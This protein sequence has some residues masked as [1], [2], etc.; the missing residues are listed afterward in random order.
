M[1]DKV[2]GSTQYLYTFLSKIQESPV[3]RDTE[4][5]QRTYATRPDIDLGR[6]SQF[7]GWATITTP[8]E[9]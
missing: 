8:F 3:S 9:D 5:K 4:S 1:L 2:M 6:T 7:L